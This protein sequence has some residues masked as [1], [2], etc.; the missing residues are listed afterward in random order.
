MDEQTPAEELPTLYRAV[1]ETVARLERAGERAYAWELRRKALR[2]YSTRW[3][4]AGRRSLQR[5]DREGHVRL[6]M[7]RRTDERAHALSASETY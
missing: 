1:L 5:L 2:T 6:A 7:T 3:D 4:E